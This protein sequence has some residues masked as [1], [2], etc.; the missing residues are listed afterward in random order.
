MPSHGA[1]LCITGL[2]DGCRR[3]Q[4]V[5]C[6]ALFIVG[7]ERRVSDGLAT[8][9]AYFPWLRKIESKAW[10]YRPALWAKDPPFRDHSVVFL[11]SPLV[12]RANFHPQAGLLRHS[13]PKVSAFPI[14][15][16]AQAP[17]LDTISLSLEFQDFNTGICR[18][19]VQTVTATSFWS[20]IW[21]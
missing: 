5:S 2:D 13:S 10:R 15:P 16:L 11:T 6:T 21:R 7:A 17:H 14:W 9:E 4:P 8:A 20:S 3:P 18:D 19:H 12:K 1:G